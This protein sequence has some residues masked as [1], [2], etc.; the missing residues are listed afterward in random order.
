M[1]AKQ[2]A[3]FIIAFSIAGGIVNGS[4]IFSYDVDVYDV[5]ED[6]T[7]VDGISEIDDSTQSSGD[8]A[9]AVDGWKMIK[10]SWDSIKTMFSVLVLPGP[11][12]HGRGVD[13]ATSTGVQTIVS[14]VEVWGLIQLFTG[15]A[16]KG[17][18]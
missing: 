7:I 14:V 2:L 5:D 3:F 9:E 1:Q 16:T 18:E 17:M 4:G 12:L 6:K 8:L 11:W 13:F 15:R 10:K